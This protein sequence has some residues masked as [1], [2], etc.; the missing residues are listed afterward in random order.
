MQVAGGAARQV[1][2][3]ATMQLALPN[4]ERAFNEEVRCDTRVGES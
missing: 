1:A 2:A 4:N 3:P